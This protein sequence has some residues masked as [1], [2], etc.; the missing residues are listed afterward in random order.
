[1]KE[2]AIA[3]NL[4]FYFFPGVSGLHINAVEAKICPETTCD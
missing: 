1:M 3:P 2:G 4:P